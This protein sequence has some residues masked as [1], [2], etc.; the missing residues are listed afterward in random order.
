VAAGDRFLPDA[1][2]AVTELVLVAA[3]PEATYAAIDAADVS[4][5]RLLGVLGSL[6]DLDRRL[7]G[8]AVR[9]KTLGE[10][11]GPG[12][13]FVPLS[14]E[15]GKLRAVGL[16]GRYSAFDR[17][18]R[19]LDPASFVSFDEPG[20][21]KVVVA[22]WLHQQNDGQTLLTCDA[23]A[24]A[25]DDDTRSTLEATSFLVVPAARQLC[26]RLLE[27]VK[28]RAEGAEDGD[29]DGDQRDADRLPAG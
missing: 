27:L 4:G 26:R 6:T 8:S 21:V 2:L 10:L 14:D 18:L 22:F 17:S 7:A 20:N 1:D 28:S 24:R 29:G 11:L 5:D 15:P 9:P 3:D 13:G 12:L 16:A 25:T 19:R 23:R